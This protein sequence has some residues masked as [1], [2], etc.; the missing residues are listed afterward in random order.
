MLTVTKATHSTCLALHV[1][2]V[3]ASCSA[4]TV[5]RDVSCFLVYFGAATSKQLFGCTR[6]TWLAIDMVFTSCHTANVNYK[7]TVMQL[8]IPSCA[9][10]IYV[11]RSTGAAAAGGCNARGV[12][13]ERHLPGCRE[14]AD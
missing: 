5:W 14:A 10:C 13:E 2:N 3:P 6:T 7:F 12:A 11:Y 9:G 8:N 4:E 1:W